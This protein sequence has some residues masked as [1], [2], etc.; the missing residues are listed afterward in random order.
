MPKSIRGQGD[1]YHFD[2]VDDADYGAYVSNGGDGFEGAAVKSTATKAIPISVGGEFNLYGVNELL[3]RPVPT[4][5]AIEEGKCLVP[6]TEYHCRVVTTNADNPTARAKRGKRAPRSRPWRRLKQSLRQGVGLDSAQAHRD[7]Q[8]AGDPLHGPL[9]VRH[10]GR[11]D[12]GFAGATGSPT[13]A[14]GKPNRLE[15]EA[16][17]KFSRAVS[18]LAAGTTYRDRL[19]AGNPTFGQSPTAARAL[20]TYTVTALEGSCP[21]QAFRGGPGAALPDCRAYE[22]V[23]PLDKEGAGHR[24]VGRIVQLP[25]PTLDQSA[26][27]GGR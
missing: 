9:R 16:P 22:M 26:G 5:E 12:S 24:P 8:P 20:T 25:P 13:P 4:E 18:G 17:V 27:E 15:G 10:A 19:P 11:I 14:R 6:E 23:S 21:N 1:D 3:G 2:Y 7:R